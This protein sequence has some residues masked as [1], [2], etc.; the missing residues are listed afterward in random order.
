MRE[1]RATIAEL[2]AILA[3]DAKLRAVITEEITAIRDEFATPRRT[4]LEHD[5]GDLEI[6]DLIDDE[7][8]VVVMTARGYIKTV[9]VDA[10]RTQARGGRG[11]AGAALKDED[12]ITH[13]IHTSAHA[14]LLFFSNRGGSIG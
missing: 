8:V 12:F 9:A 13:L 5:D 6:E 2:E 1:L 3:D 7:E 4:S 10:F 14:Y 11:V